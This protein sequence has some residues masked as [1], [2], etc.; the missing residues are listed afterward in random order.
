MKIL[1]LSH[2]E[3][4]F[5]EYYLF[6]GLCQI[7]GDENVVTYPYKKSYFGEVDTSYTLDDG[8]TGMTAPGAY[9]IPRKKNEWNYDE[10]INRITEFNF[11]ILSS[12]RTYA[13]NALKQLKRDFGEIPLP[14]VFTEHEDGDNIRYDIINEF[15]PDIIF[16]RELLKSSSYQDIYP[17]PFSSAINGFPQ[18]DDTQKKYDIFALFGMTWPLRK[19]VIEKLIEWGH[20]NT[21]LGIDTKIRADM[22]DMNKKLLGYTEYLTGI[23]QSKIAITVRGH[24]RD[25]VRRWEIPAYETLMLICDPGIVVPYDF[26]DGKTAVFFK[27]NL[28]DLKDKIDYYLAHDDE[29]IKIAKAGKEHL[30]KYHTNKKRAEYFLNIVNGKLGVRN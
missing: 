20:K 12:G 22:V 8:T 29:R 9:I 1:Y 18:I 6:S 3:A 14:L 10:I 28:R 23:A 19:E 5:G 11:I 25:T 15:N 17:L 7:L 26:E 27:E 16:K 4:D 30:L 2:P 21:Y 13:V 24:G